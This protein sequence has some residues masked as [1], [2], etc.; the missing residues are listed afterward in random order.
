MSGWSGLFGLWT[1]DIL[2]EYIPLNLDLV[3]HYRGH[4]IT[5]DSGIH[6]ILIEIHHLKMFIFPY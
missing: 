1:F 4:G 3:D 5:L 2:N 6:N